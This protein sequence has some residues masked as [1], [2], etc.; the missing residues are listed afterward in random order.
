MVESKEAKAILSPLFENFMQRIVFE[1]SVEMVDNL[2]NLF[3]EYDH[4]V[5]D[6]DEPA[7]ARIFP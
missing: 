3:C 2:Y 7:L 4:R 1:W 6:L 5:K